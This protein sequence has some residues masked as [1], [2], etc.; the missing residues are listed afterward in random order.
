GV[1]QPGSLDLSELPPKVAGDAAAAL[2]QLPFATPSAAPRHPDSFQYE[3]TVI[4]GDER[5]RAVLDEAQVPDALR[6]L[7]DAALDRG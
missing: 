7:L 4:D 3:I 5:R 6:P 1:A 2:A